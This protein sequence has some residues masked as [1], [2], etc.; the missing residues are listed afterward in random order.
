MYIRKIFIIKA[1]GGTALNLYPYFIIS[2]LFFKNKRFRTIMKYVFSAK[3]KPTFI[4]PKY[5]KSHLGSI[6]WKAIEEKYID[7]K[8]WTVETPD[9]SKKNHHF[10]TK[11]TSPNYIHY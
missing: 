4:E 8:K 10:Y 1:I 5:R 11:K 2:F 9:Y 6:V 7:A 3:Y